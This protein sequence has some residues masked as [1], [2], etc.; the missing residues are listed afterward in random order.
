MEQVTAAEALFRKIDPKFRF[1]ETP[2]KVTI[3][4]RTRLLLCG[5]EE[6]GPY[7]LFVDHGG[8]RGLP[9]SNECVGLSRMDAYGENVGYCSAL[10]LAYHGLELIEWPGRDREEAEILDESRRRAL[11]R[12]ARHGTDG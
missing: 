11:A 1:W 10:L 12:R 9:G 4:K 8:R 7:G 3:A 2:V 6:I 5:R